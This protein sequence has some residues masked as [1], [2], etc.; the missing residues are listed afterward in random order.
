MNMNIKLSG[1]TE[2]IVAG[3]IK[4][5][6]AKTKTDAIMVGLLELNNKYKLLERQEDEEDVRD[7]KRILSEIKS[8]KQKAYSK[9]EFEKLTSSKV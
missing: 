1:I 8:G 5:G 6:I 2:E 4:A 3:A 9:E 7:A